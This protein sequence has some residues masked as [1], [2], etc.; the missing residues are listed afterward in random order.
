MVNH[1]A[2][3]FLNPVVKSMYPKTVLQGYIR[4]CGCQEVFCTKNWADEVLRKYQAEL[5]TAA[6]ILAD[7]RCPEAVKRL[8]L[9]CPDVDL[10]YPDILPI[11]LHSASELSQT[12][13]GSDILVITPCQSLSEQGKSL[14]LPNLSFMTW[15]AFVRMQEEKGIPAPVAVKLP[16]SPVP[17]GYFHGI[18]GQV[19]LM[20][21]E[22][23]FCEVPQIPPDTRLIEMLYCE[24]GCHNGDGVEL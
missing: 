14:G 5:N 3:I 19:F 4:L 20:T 6:G 24:N 13:I 1:M 22:K 17:P 16:K 7:M 18:C 10:V 11:L 9:L 15:K 21:G 8:R 2:F 12:F 23:A